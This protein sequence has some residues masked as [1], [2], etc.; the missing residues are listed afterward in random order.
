MALEPRDSS[1]PSFLAPHRKRAPQQP[2]ILPIPTSAKPKPKPVPTTVNIDPLPGKTTAL[3]ATPSAPT[4]VPK[5]K[6][7]TVHTSTTAI[8]G[9]GSDG[10]GVSSEP[11]GTNTGLIVGVT[12]GVVAVIALLGVLLFRRRR[13]NQLRGDEVR[14]AELYQQ[15]RMMRVSGSMMARGD[16]HGRSQHRRGGSSLHGLMS[17]GRTKVSGETDGEGGNRENS[18]GYHGQN[19]QHHDQPDWFAKKKPLEYYRQVPPIE[20]LIKNM[21]RRDW[22]ST[23][24]DLGYPGHDAAAGSTEIVAARSLMSSA[25]PEGRGGRESIPLRDA[26]TPKNA[27]EA[28]RN[29]HPRSAMRPIQAQQHQ[30][31]HQHQE[32]SSSQNNR[33]SPIRPISPMGSVYTSGP[34]SRPVSTLNPRPSPNTSPY[35]RPPPPPIPE[36]PETQT[37]TFS[38]P[39]PGFYDFIP[40]ESDQLLLEDHSPAATHSS[41]AAPPP[42]P[43]A[44]RPTSTSADTFPVGLNSIVGLVQSGYTPLYSSTASTSTTHVSDRAPV[45]QLNMK[46]VGSG[47]SVS[48]VS[49]SESDMS[50]L[51]AGDGPPRMGGRKARVNRAKRRTLDTAADQGLQ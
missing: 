41:S 21:G 28:H 38:S 50:S 18:F 40:L 44:T 4:P 42:I 24:S 22:S 30:Q 37:P 12:L 32:Q 2:G 15:Q 29:Y 19:S 35:Y 27:M 3:P 48:P 46:V 5:T 23:R 10:D 45:P 43:R 7:T 1:P 11:S 26:T 9:S 25:G 6:V 49:P 34:D 17:G 33:L 51:S 39:S 13:R 16:T 31:Q 36:R 14:E 20:E 8:P 47:T